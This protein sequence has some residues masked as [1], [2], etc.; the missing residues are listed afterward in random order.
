MKLKLE[1][2]YNEEANCWECYGLEGVD[3]PGNNQLNPAQDGDMLAWIA[4]RPHYCDRGHF[5]VNME[6]GGLDEADHWPNYYMSLRRAMDEAE[7]FLQWR[8][9]KIP[10]QQVFPWEPQ[11]AEETNPMDIPS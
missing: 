6:L 7:D 9:Q 3:G 8:L 4:K 11:A 10:L 5:L 1:W 2:R